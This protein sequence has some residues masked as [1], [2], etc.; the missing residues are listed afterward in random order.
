[1]IVFEKLNKRTIVR[2]KESCKGERKIKGR[3]N[4]DKTLKTLKSLSVKNLIA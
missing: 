4:D 3:I 1:M 2:K